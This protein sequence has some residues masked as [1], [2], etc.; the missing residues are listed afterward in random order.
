MRRG[1]PI[2]A[3][4]SPTTFAS[5]RREEARRNDQQ[6]IKR[7]GAYSNYGRTVVGTWGLQGVLGTPRRVGAE[8]SGCGAGELRPGAR[9][10]ALR[11]HS[12][13]G[14]FRARQEL[15]AVMAGGCDGGAPGDAQLGCVWAVGASLPHFPVGRLAA[16]ADEASWPPCPPAAVLCVSWGLF[17]PRED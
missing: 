6:P 12:A 1:G 13:S 15:R 5:G 7:R 2:L 14:T 11:G 9:G 10:D 8:E 3:H 4:R 17:H 16:E